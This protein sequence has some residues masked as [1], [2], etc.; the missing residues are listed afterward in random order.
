MAS[1]GKKAFLLRMDP[2]LWKELEQWSQGRI[3]QRQWA[4]RVSAQ[5]GGQETQT[6]HIF[7]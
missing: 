3:A 6:R 2:K 7:E 1:P 5:T 4:N